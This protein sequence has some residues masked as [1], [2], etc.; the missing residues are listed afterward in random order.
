MLGG[1]KALL[2]APA[3]EN[4][5]E[6]RLFFACADELAIEWY[7]VVWRCYFFRKLGIWSWGFSK[8]REHFL[9]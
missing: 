9:G 3:E 4:A 1:G 8:E 2:S 7:M 6:P 5:L